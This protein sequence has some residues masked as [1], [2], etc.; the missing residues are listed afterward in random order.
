MYIRQRHAWDNDLPKQRHRNNIKCINAQ[1]ITIYS[2]V[3][4]IEIISLPT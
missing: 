2:N 4:H 3:K 1:A